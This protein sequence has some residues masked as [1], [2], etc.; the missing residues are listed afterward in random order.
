MYENICYKIY[1]YH[2]N[3]LKFF[4]HY[5]SFL[6]ELMT[7]TKPLLSLLDWI[8]FFLTVKCVNRSSG[9]RMKTPAFRCW[10]EWDT[11]SISVIFSEFP[12]FP[13]AR[14]KRNVFVNLLNQGYKLFRCIDVWIMLHQFCFSTYKVMWLTCGIAIGMYRSYI[15]AS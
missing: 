10:Q 2:Y 14:R 9:W 11:F 1:G 8:G 3:L 5:N 6:F 15:P 7:V 13:W 4:N 12:K